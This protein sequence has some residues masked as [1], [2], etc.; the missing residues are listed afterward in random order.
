M[1]SSGGKDNSPEGKQVSPD[2]VVCEALS[3]LQD[4]L[5]HGFVVIFKSEEDRKYYLEQ[6][7]VH[8]EFVKSIEGVV[9]KAVILDY[10]PSSF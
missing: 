5:S 2:S 8:L 9:E 7:P 4:G 6:D 3:F 1:D 10:E